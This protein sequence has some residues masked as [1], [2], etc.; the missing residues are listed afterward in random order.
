MI[1]QKEVTIKGENYLLT[2]FGGIK[3]VKYGKRVGRIILP[4]M[5]VV[6]GSE[7]EEANMGKV[8]EVV[9]DNLDQLDEDLIA[10]LIE[11]VTKGGVAID[12]DKEFAGNYDTL[13]ML[14]QEVIQFNFQS[15]F[16][17]GLDGSEAE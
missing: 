10:K 16:Q 6:F 3:G 12:F 9:C 8:I 11:S 17:L 13:F 1:E 7:G 14:L 4:I 15:L 2:Q 5:S